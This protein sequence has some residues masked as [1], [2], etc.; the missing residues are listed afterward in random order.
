[1]VVGDL[2]VVKCVMSSNGFLVNCVW[3]L[4]LL[5]NYYW[6][7]KYVWM[8]IIVGWYEIIVYIVVW[9]KFVY[10]LCVCLVCCFE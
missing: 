2:L 5:D 9:L 6:V 4:I 10:R 7:I 8:I 1:M 3:F